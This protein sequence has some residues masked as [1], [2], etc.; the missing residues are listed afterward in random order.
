VQTAVAYMKSK[1]E[2]SA[3]TSLGLDGQQIC[4]KFHVQWET[5]S[6]KLNVESNTGSSTLASGSHTPAKETDEEDKE[7]NDIVE[8]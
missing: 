2:R 1:H 6:Q 5:L 4:L 3:R 8:E 7:K